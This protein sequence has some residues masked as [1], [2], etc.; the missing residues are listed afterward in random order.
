MQT[1]S[2]RESPVKLKQVAQAPVIPIRRPVNSQDQQTNAISKLK[3]TRAVSYLFDTRP[4][5]KAKKYDV[6]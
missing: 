3:K 4:I 5:F 6:L 1:S 2:R